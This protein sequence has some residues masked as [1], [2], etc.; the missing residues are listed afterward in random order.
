VTTSDESLPYTQAGARATPGDRLN[1]LR[2]A[3]GMTYADL[4]AAAEAERSWVSRQC[5]GKSAITL[6][7]CVAFGEAL[8]VAPSYIAF[9][10]RLR[11]EK[12]NRNTTPAPATVMQRVELLRI[13]KQWTISDMCQRASIHGS[14]LTRFYDERKVPPAAL[15]IDH[16][17]RL[18]AA[19]GVE[20]AWLGFGGDD[21]T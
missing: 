19:F 10:A 3:A 2:V 7:Q 21:P 16:V 9:G 17:S 11:R 8:G 4:A 1:N 18:A 6:A 20:E 14:W 5:Q 12:P 13:A 15:S